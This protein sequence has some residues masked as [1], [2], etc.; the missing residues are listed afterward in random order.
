MDPERWMEGTISDHVTGL[1]S[2]VSVNGENRTR[3]NSEFA[4]LKVSA[5]SYGVFDSQACKVINGPELAR[6]RTNPKA[7]QVIISRSN[8][9]D[10]VGASLDSHRLADT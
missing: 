1:E 7:D 9:E 8:T 3:H 6:A 10:L 2:G 5:V 4:V